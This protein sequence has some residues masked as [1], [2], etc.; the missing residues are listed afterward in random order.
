MAEHFDLIVIGAGPGGY[1]CAISA[2][3]EGLKTALFEKESLG[4][5]CLNV[6]CIP[7][8]Y[9]LDKA[10]VIEKIRK[11]SYSG[12][13]RNAGE[14]SL[15]KIQKG[16]KETIK[17]LVNG[18][19]Y[20]LKANGI[21]LIT[22]KADLLDNRKVLCDGKTYSA[23][24][25]IIST[26]SIPSN[27]NIPGAEYTINSTEILE[28]NRV[29][30]NLIV[31]GGGVIG[32]EMASAFASF[33]SNVTVLEMMDTL[34]PEEEKRNVTF[35]L[36]AMKKRGIKIITGAKL[37][38]IEKSGEKLSAY[39]SVNGKEETAEGNQVLMAAGRRPSLTGID[40]EKLGLELTEKGFIKTDKN[41]CT[42]LLGVYAIGDAAG[43][44]QLAHAAYAKGKIALASI[45]KKKT[46]A[47][48]D[49]MPRCIYTMPCLAGVGLTEK[50]AKEKGIEIAIG[51]F[52]Y[53]SNG[54][55]LAEGTEGKVI[56]LMEKKTKKT[57]GIHIVGENA[58]ELISFAYAAIVKEMTLD[59]WENIIIAHP[60]LAEMLKEAALD[61]FGKAVHKK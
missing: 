44:Y 51:N 40:A 1:S 42:N 33:G 37:K 46:T 6:G 9:L 5:T 35:L 26:G 32:M 43:G 48:M 17:K 54:M 19:A 36:S 14:F 3:K 29:P 41:M 58:S 13:L 18:I 15:N 16:K 23:D 30:E 27:L 11:F 8:K 10:A 53:S 59:E 34:Y 57:I 38:K 22:G 55:A 45:L 50:Q 52:D 61:A 25:I 47:S 12:V 28:L 31:I 4:G 60:S 21:T 49:L 56:V 24:N 20:L 2:A 39:Y 7:T